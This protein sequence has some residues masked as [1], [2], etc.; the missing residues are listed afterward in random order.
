MSSRRAEPAGRLRLEGR[1]VDA[2][3]S[4][5]SGAKVWID[6]QAVTSER[7]GAFVFD[8]LVRR[9]YEVRAVAGDRI[10]GPRVIAVA[11]RSAPVVIELA[12]APR[13]RVRVV[14]TTRAPIANAGVRVI[15][16][17][18][19]VSTDTDGMGTLAAHR[20]DGTIEATAPGY[21]PRRT[22]IFVTA[23]GIAE[24]ATIVL[25]EG[26]AVT[27]RVLDEAR[28][29]IPNA[30]IRAMAS[31]GA[32]Q[33]IAVTD[34]RGVFTIPSAIGI[35]RLLVID[36]EHEPTWSEP[37]DV[38][39]TITDLEIVM[40]AGAIYAGRVIDEDGVPVAGAR[41][42]ADSGA[43]D[44]HRFCGST[45]ADGAFELRGLHRGI[46][47]TDAEHDAMVVHAVSDDGA[48]EDVIVTFEDRL[49]LRDQLLVL[50]RLDATETIAGV[51][52]DDTGAPVANTVLNA[53][54]R[55]DT[56]NP[57]AMIA[58][59]RGWPDPMSATSTLTN[60]L[61]EFT[62]RG[63]PAGEYGLWAGAF[64]DRSLLMLATAFS[65]GMDAS[66]F[67]ESA[68]TGDTNVRVVAPR[69]A[70]IS[71][72]L[73]F[74][75]TGEHAGSF[76]VD[77]AGNRELSVGF[78]G[79]DGAFDL[80]DLRPGNYRLRVRGPGF[81][82]LTTYAHVEAGQHLD[83]GA[84]E[85][86]RGRTV[87]GTVVDSTGRGIA[88]ASVIIRDHGIFHAVGRFDAALDP[89]NASTDA[90][91]AF[92]I[93]NVPI[94]RS[95]LVIGADHP[96]FGRSAPIPIPPHE[97]PLALTVVECGSIAGTLTRAGLPL[98]G[99]SV[100]AGWPLAGNTLADADGRFVLPRLPSGPIE[101]RVEVLAEDLKRPHH[102]IVFVEPGK[103]IEVAIDVPVGAIELAVAVVPR[104]TSP[105]AYAR[106]F[107]YR[108]T[109]AFASYAELSMQLSAANHGWI[110]WARDDDGPGFQRRPV[111]E[112]LVAGDYTVCALP[113][114][115]NPHDQEVMMRFSRER[116]AAAVY[117]TPVRVAA[118]PATQ[119]LTIEI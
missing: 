3:G 16:H 65:V 10:G 52:V 41:V 90:T 36:D 47:R 53:A 17:D 49:A 88:G 73:V 119:T 66:P 107:L 64:A 95:L 39:R 110:D 81:L 15:G 59:R 67:I 77:L 112:R 8:R 19:A 37:I 78:P 43:L 100:G 98:T 7:D 35:Q 117:C 84:I 116:G 114:P 31:D 104:A 92:A 18:A 42:Y 91:G 75:D 63:L 20:G 27:G 23:S 85:I 86:D 4:G 56:S 93:A 33:E 34:P 103:Q 80:R 70:R 99:A 76:E 118:E 25:C 71:G 87:R 38:D 83:L 57:I 45:D 101:L 14:D 60:A 54:V 97:D 1:V 109:M 94:G 115:G 30:R 50:R 32:D 48:S 44:P 61:G 28:G 12:D 9:S 22:G 24:H 21:S 29:P 6:E 68:T 2:A 62:F 106:V 82:E 96:S 108:G 55:V 89:T 72:A 74:A 51:L 26:F 113:Y 102:A 69:H 40:K 58:T 111:F 46:G 13:V 79:V 11:P 105:C 5:I